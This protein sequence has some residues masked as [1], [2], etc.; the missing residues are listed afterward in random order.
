MSR[1]YLSM[2]GNNGNAHTRTPIA[3]SPKGS[4][5]K[6]SGLFHNGQYPHKDALQEQEDAKRSVRI[7]ETGGG[8]FEQP[9]DRSSHDVFREISLVMRVMLLGSA[10][11]SASGATTEEPTATITFS[12]GA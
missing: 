11:R 8:T 2:S 1:K 6:C 3:A 10:R 12:H 4:Y 9:F 7:A 5:G